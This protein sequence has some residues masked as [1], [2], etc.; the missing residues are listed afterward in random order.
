MGH[1]EIRDSERNVAIS[2]TIPKPAT[3][4]KFNS[5]A[6]WSAFGAA[7]EI[8]TALG[9]LALLGKTPQ[10]KTAQLAR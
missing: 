7:R 5:L 10:N 2:L 6:D 8:W 3:V 4:G 1:P 9:F